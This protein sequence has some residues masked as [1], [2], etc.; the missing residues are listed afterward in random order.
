[1]AGFRPRAGKRTEETEEL[2][3]LSSNEHFAMHVPSKEIV[4][5]VNGPMP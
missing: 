4:G 3:E 5:R 1:M 2:A